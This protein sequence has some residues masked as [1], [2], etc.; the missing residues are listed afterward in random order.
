MS[1]RSIG[2]GAPGPSGVRALRHLGPILIAMRRRFPTLP[3]PL[4]PLALVGAAGVAL[5]V[6]VLV[7][8]SASSPPPI[9][10]PRE[11]LLRSAD[12]ARREGSAHY[13][14]R[15]D[16]KVA[17][18]DPG[19]AEPIDLQGTTLEGDLSIE[20]SAGTAALTIPGLGTAL[21]AVLVGEDAWLRIGLLGGGWRRTSAAE[22]PFDFLADPAAVTGRL[23]ET[24]DAL[25]A[26]PR[27]G[28]DEGCGETRCGVV[29]VDL[30]AGSAPDV[31]G[32]LF[33]GLIP[34]ST[35][36]PFPLPSAGE[37]S[38]PV[39][40]GFTGSGRVTVYV[41]RSSLRPVRLRFLVEG[42]AA[43]EVSIDV[44][45]TRWGEPVEIAPPR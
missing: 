31:L 39:P 35:G 30:P 26:P 4:L 29:T 10:D 23:G 5:V 28:P 22:S 20:R 3:R 42:G 13:L 1:V 38:F 24:L 15:I 34:G 32:R 9:D 17:F 45:L 33:G 8:Q 19:T 11:L 16:G 18:D 27:L 44:A 2:L 36:S 14:A 7:T 6:L 37:G 12:A 21:E 41:E 43:G 25:P 40:S